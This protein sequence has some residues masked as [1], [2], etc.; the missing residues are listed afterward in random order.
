MMRI[1]I[2]WLLLAAFACAM[3]VFVASEPMLQFTSC[4]IESG[5]PACEESILTHYGQ[6]FLIVLAVPALLCLVPAVVPVR[7]VAWAIAV[8][9]L[10]G[11]LA[12]FTPF[13]LP[14]AV[15]GLTLAAL[16]DRLAGS[17]R[18]QQR[19]PTETSINF[20]AQ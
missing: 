9:L 10:L 6:G 7:G 17:A 4:E 15:L 12:V 5:G 14:V 2:A 18:K 11:F 20:T 13:Y 19:D 3:S 1:R 8:T 16:H